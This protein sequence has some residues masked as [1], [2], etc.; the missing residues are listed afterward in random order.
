VFPMLQNS[1]NVPFWISPSV[2]SCIYL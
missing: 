1:V 2:F